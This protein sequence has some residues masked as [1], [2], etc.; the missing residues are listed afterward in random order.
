MALK[1]YFV[2]DGNQALL[3]SPTSPIINKT[4]PAEPTNIAANKVAAVEKKG[5]WKA[6]LGALIH[7]P[8]KLAISRIGSRC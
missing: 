7:K 1:M 6:R 8:H 3:S 4:R 5:C 2:L